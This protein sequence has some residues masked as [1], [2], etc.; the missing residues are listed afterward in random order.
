MAFHFIGLVI[1]HRV[2]EGQFLTRGDVPHSNED[3]LALQAQIWLAGVVQVH[4][5]TLALSQ[6]RRADK[7]VLGNLDLRRAEFLADLIAL[8]AAKDITSFHDDN[9]IFVDPSLGKEAAPVDGARSLF[10]LGRK[11]GE[12]WHYRFRSTTS[13]AKPLSAGKLAI[14]AAASFG[15]LVKVVLSSVKSKRSAAASGFRE[16]DLSPL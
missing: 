13:I 12:V 1:G 2:V 15:A 10:D 7:E 9:L 11:I 5:A 8:G 16:P 14:F 6:R 4:H 3:D